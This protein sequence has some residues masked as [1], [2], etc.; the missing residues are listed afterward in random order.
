MRLGT[1]KPAIRRRRTIAYTPDTDLQGNRQSLL[2]PGNPRIREAG[3]GTGAS[4]LPAPR[5]GRTGEGS[6]VVCASP[7][8]KVETRSTERGESQDR[9]DRGNNRLR[10]GVSSSVSG[11]R[12]EHLGRGRNRGDRDGHDQGI[13]SVLS[14]QSGHDAG[15][16]RSATVRRCDA[17]H[18]GELGSCG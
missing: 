15:D 3:L 10:R 9:T 8:A 5:S 16:V 13:V 18:S 17:G 1:E 4:V 7:C 11:G 12:S 14:L 2:R 6:G